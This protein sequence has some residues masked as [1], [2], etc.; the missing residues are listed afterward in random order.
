MEKHGV[1][2]VVV[3]YH[4]D[5]AVLINLQA[6]RPQVDWLVVVD[7]GSTEAELAPLRQLLAADETSS[8][9]ENGEN[10]GIATALNIG[11]RQGMSYNAEYALLFDQD[12]RVTEGF[13]QTLCHAYTQSPQGRRLGILVPSYI[14]ERLNRALPPNRLAD[15]SLEAAMTSGSL[16]LMDTLEHHGMFVD[17]LFID[18]V[19]YEFS[20]RLRKAGLVI[21]EYSGAV[22]VHSPGTPRRQRLL[23]LLTYQISNY[24]PIR[25]YYQQR[26]K[27]WVTKHYWKAF[28]VFCC[29][30]F[31]FSGKD[32][33]KLIVAEDNKA[34]K[35]RAFLRGVFD[36]IRGKMGRLEP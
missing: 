4:P 3:T 6:L 29:K 7:N 32:F 5:S 9:I 2:A 33:I 8:L 22:L 10:L 17:Q 23:G 25:Q 20:L 24:S 19:D 28:P 13:V 30:L 36:G 11:V 14:D 21:E 26:N 27:V 35:L 15:G 34:N 1:C 31:Y 18:G 16:I 12:S